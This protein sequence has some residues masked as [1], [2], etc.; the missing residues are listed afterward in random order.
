MTAPGVEASLELQRRLG[1]S[2]RELWNL[3]VEVEDTATVDR[4]LTWVEMA[5]ADWPEASRRL[6]GRRAI[7]HVAVLP[8]ATLPVYSTVLFG[9]GAAL[10][11][12]DVT[13][14]PAR[15][16]GAPA[17]EIFVERVLAPCGLS[18]QITRET[19]REVVEQSSSAAGLV[20]TGSSENAET[21]AAGLP[22]HV[23]MAYQGP[24]VCAAVIGPT[25]DVTKAVRRIVSDRLFN[26]G[27]DCLSIERLYVHSARARDTLATLQHLSRR[28]NVA[29][30]RAGQGQ[31][32][33]I[34]EPAKFRTRLQDGL[35]EAIDLC[36][37]GGEVADGVFALT[38]MTCRADARTVLRES[39]GPLL[40]VVVYN[41]T[42]ELREMLM[43]GDF[44]L[45][46]MLFD[47]LPPFGVLDF[48][49]VS[50][51]RSLYDAESYLAPFGGYRRSSF[52]RQA[53][54]RTSGPYW[55]PWIMSRPIA[56]GIA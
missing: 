18:I 17:V 10:P 11:G 25:T 46:L 38:V 28:L 36:V 48:A 31:L 8:P 26:M 44:A 27:Q 55:L 14:R 5:F 42:A 51:N 45:G 35:S 20:F 1:E 2:R 33:P 53:G 6:A 30:R 19:G 22:D 40:P 21:I 4:E 56:E 41:S 3:L 49:H 54:R 43:L 37:P 52:I 9:A 34:Q 7:G 50:V 39:Y 13:L 29:E 32:F 23:V 15:G 24:G 12:N 16:S 47:S